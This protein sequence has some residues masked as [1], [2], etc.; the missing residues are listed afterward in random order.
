[1]LAFLWGWR[2]RILG[3]Q[4][5]ALADSFA[6]VI[7][8]GVL[9]HGLWLA[10]WALVG[11]KDC[12]WWGRG[13]RGVVWVVAIDHRPRGTAIL[14]SSH[15]ANGTRHGIASNATCHLPAFFFLPR[16]AAIRLG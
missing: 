13:G 15:V 7:G 8:G 12:C 10:V 11:V 14:C 16:V 5:L 1:M 6:F 4:E 9:D 3:V 2:F